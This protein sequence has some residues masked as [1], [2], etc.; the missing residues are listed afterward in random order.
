MEL[1]NQSAEE[2]LQKYMEYNEAPDV[3]LGG[4]EYIPNELPEMEQS[5]FTA[6]QPTPLPTGSPYIQSRESA[7]P[8]E[9]MEISVDE[10][11]PPPKPVDPIQTWAKAANNYRA[12]FSGAKDLKAQIAKVESDGMGG[13]SADNPTS[14]AVGKYQFVWSLW[15]PEIA[16]FTGIKDPETFKKNPQAQ[17]KFFDYYQKTTLEPQLQT[18]KKE[19]PDSGLTDIQIMKLLHFRGLGKKDK[20]DKGLRALLSQGKLGSK[21]ESNNLTAKEYLKRSE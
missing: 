4:L 14:S 3:R 16:K 10:I 8:A 12:T 11:A 7:A 21:L 1:N 19:F 17:E 9:S 2:K 5:T 15:G 20:S 13:Y 18:V 6:P